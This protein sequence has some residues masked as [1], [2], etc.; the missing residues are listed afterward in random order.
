MMNAEQW[1]TKINAQQPPTCSEWLTM[2]AQHIHKHQHIIIQ[3]HIYHGLHLHHLSQ[4][5]IVYQ[6]RPA[7]DIRFSSHGTPLSQLTN[8]NIYACLLIKID[9]F[10]TTLFRWIF[11]KT[12]KNSSNRVDWHIYVCFVSNHENYTRATLYT[13]MDR[14]NVFGWVRVVWYK[15]APNP[16]DSSLKSTIFTTGLTL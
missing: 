1:Q 5:T 14:D 13:I 3:L 16:F 8:K 12:K 9:N 7:K 10:K 11:A 6:C 15:T 2:C 4:L